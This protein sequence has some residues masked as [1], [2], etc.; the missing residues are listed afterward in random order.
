[1]KLKQKIEDGLTEITNL[2][3]EIENTQKE[4]V[5][6]MGAIGESRSKETGNHVKEL[7]NTQNF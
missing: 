6:T 5:F 2:N 4:V 7:Q 3:H 1:M